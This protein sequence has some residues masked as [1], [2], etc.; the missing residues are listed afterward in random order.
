V[1]GTSEKN[2]SKKLL[3]HPN[4]MSMWCL[5]SYMFN[6]FADKLQMDGLP[7]ILAVCAS[8]IC[9]NEMK[10]TVPYFCKHFRCCAVMC[11][12]NWLSTVVH[13]THTIR[14]QC[15]AMALSLY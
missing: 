9:V 10:P 11:L 2:Y 7:K 15:Y 5:S 4:K 14:I 13:D 6:K 8:N 12:S 3:Q 1:C